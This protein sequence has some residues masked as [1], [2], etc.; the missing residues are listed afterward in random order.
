[1]KAA[2]RA[3]IQ[4]EL[5]P[6]RHSR[7]DNTITRNR[8]NVQIEDLRRAR[9]QLRDCINRMRDVVRNVRNCHG[10]VPRRDFRGSR[11]TR[12]EGRLERASGRVDSQRDRHIRNRER[13][14]SRIES[15]RDARNRLNTT[16]GMQNSRINALETELRG[17]W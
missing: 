15:V 2:R 5:P 3:Q 4:A 11:R 14:I 7:D 13:V 10:V 9:D 8:L 12:I 17:L 6:L 16:I 1:V